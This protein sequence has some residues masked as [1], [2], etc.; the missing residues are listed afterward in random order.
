MQPMEGG[1]IRDGE[2]RKL[3]RIFAKLLP[4]DRETVL[5]FAEFLQQRPAGASPDPDG[6][7]ATAEP[8]DIPRPQSESVVKAIRRLSTTYPMV[9]KSEML[10]ETSSLMTQHIVQGRS[11]REVIDELESLFRDHYSAWKE[12]QG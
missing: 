8:L 12:K 6:S 10:N 3:V 5:A 2:T 1:L 7:V 9:D 4:S 11:A